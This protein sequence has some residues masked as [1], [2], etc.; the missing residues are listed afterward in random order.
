MERIEKG[1][2]T[3]QRGN[4]RGVYSPPNT[5]EILPEKLCDVLTD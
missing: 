2:E 5:Q 1:A 3:F 4:E